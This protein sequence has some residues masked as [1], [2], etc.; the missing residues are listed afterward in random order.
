MIKVS[1]I[2]HT[3]QYLE[4][5]YKFIPCSRIDIFQATQ[6]I[7]LYAKLLHTSRWMKLIT[8]LLP[9]LE[10][11]NMSIEVQ[12]YIQHYRNQKLSLPNTEFHALAKTILYS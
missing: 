10:N 6:A 11:L 9:I 2:P 8:S 12:W 4:K 1:R 3:W 5:K 7:A